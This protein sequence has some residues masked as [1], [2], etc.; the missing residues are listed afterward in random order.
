[1]QSAY[2]DDDDEDDVGRYTNVSQ[3]LQETI[4]AGLEALLLPPLTSNC[5]GVEGAGIS[6]ICMQDD[7][8]EAAISQ[9]A[10]SYSAFSFAIV[11]THT[12]SLEAVPAA[13]S[14]SS[15]DLLPG[16]CPAF[17]FATAFDFAA[18][19][20][21]ADVAAPAAVASNEHTTGH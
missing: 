10:S 15:S 17:D 19:F 6:T 12:L 9:T 21:Q 3:L 4:S 7:H 1:M 5:R 20:S 13:S 2:D 14:F 8:S 16:M 11:H 18:V